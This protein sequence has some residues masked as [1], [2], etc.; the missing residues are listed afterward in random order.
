MICSC[1]SCRPRHCCCWCSCCSA[2]GAAGC[3]GFAVVTTYCIAPREVAC[4][5]S[6]YP[7]HGGFFLSPNDTPACNETTVDG[8]RSPQGNGLLANG[9]PKRHVVL[10]EEGGPAGGGSITIRLCHRLRL[11][12][13]AAGGT[14]QGARETVEPTKAY[15]LNTRC[16]LVSIKDYTCWTSIAGAR[17]CSSF[18]L[19]SSNL[20]RVLRLVQAQPALCPLFLLYTHAHAG[21][22]GEG[23]R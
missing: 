11:G 3:C 7:P 19:S 21:S 12:G 6:K 4:K 14:L 20:S 15:V 1:W 13:A 22:F 5:S 17:P 9:L 18:A 10:Q 2:A 23:V 16:L 8:E